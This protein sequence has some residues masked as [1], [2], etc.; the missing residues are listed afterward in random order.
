MPQANTAEGVPIRALGITSLLQVISLN[1]IVSN[2]QRVK[3]LKIE[4]GGNEKL[5]FKVVVL[6]LFFRGFYTCQMT[7]QMMTS[8]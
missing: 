2:T 1:R 6:F 4:T 5:S 7:S 3:S 8:F